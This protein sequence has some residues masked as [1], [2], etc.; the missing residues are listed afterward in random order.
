MRACIGVA[1]GCHRNCSY[2]CGDVLDER[3]ERGRVQVVCDKCGRV[4]VGPE[5]RLRPFD[6]NLFGSIP[7]PERPGLRRR[8][9]WDTDW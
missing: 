6:E 3:A 1:A 5:S 4:A 2:V 9:A 7:P 8:D